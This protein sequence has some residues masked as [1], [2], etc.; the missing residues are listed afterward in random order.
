MIYETKQQP[1]D[2][3]SKKFYCMVMSEH[4]S[5]LFVCMFFL[6]SIGFMRKDTMLYFKTMF[7]F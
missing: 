2:Y 7:A 5:L 3:N 6:T 1:R 4:L